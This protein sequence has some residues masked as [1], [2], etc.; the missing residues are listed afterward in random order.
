MF[1]KKIQPENKIVF[2]END[3]SLNTTEKC[4]IHVN[5]YLT[6]L[7]LLPLPPPNSNKTKQK[8]ENKR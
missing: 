6:S 2:N 4:V 8:K 5:I 1:A 7:Q 3:G